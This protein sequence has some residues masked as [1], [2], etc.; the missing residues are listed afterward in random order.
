M[1]REDIKRY[2][3]VA[4]FAIV[5]T[6]IVHDVGIRYGFWE[7]RESA[8][9]FFVMMP[10]FYGSVPVLTMWI[11]KFT[12]GR[13]W[14]YML[15]N[16][17][18][19]IGFAFYQLGVFFPSKGIYALV[20]ITSFQVWLINIV[21]AISLYIYEKWQEGELVIALKNFVG[22]SLQPAATKPSFK[23]KDKDE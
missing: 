15:V 21:H 11:F 22:A 16:A 4:L 12:N 2:M 17:I 10:Y 14:I 20:G 5:T 19:D 8:Y 23:D 3:P 6:T 7:V 13:F 18:L 1:K 9:P